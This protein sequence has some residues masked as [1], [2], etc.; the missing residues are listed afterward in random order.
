MDVKA[1][2]EITRDRLER[3]I[4][5][6]AYIVVQHGPRYAPLLDRLEEEHRKRF[7][8]PV[9]RARAILDRYKSAGQRRN[10]ILLSTDCK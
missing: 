9:D 7:G 3:A 4:V 8:D 6:L 10:A 2:S 5:A 1:M